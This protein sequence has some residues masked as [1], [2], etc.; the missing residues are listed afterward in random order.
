MKGER[1]GLCDAALTSVKEEEEEA[2]VAG[3]S[4][5][6]RFRPDKTSANLTGSSRAKIAR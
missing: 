4:L 5:R 2:G 1:V 3:E 6:P